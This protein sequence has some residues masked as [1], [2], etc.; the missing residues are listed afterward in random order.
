MKYTLVIFIFL[1]SISCSKKV[2][3]F[4]KIQVE[5]NSGLLISPS[6]LEGEYYV[7]TFLSPECP[8]SE[9]YTRTLKQLQENYST[10]N[11]QFYYI[12]PGTFYPK[13]QIAQFARLYSMPIDRFL[14][15]ENYQLRDFC[16]ASTTP[17]TY[18]LDTK[19]GIFYS[20]A[21]DNWAITL[22]KQRQL[23]SDHYLVDAIES[24]LIGEKVKVTSTRAIGCII[25]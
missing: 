7:F 4:T 5:N 14:Y 15:D 17:E 13:P 25:E 20:G 9:N 24:V 21:I 6:S 3:E 22:G 19:G 12:F 10:K 18:L 11:I 2:K 8:L 16:K 1:L 23:I